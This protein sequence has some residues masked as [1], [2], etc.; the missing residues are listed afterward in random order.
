MTAREKRIEELKKRQKKFKENFGY[1]SRELQVLIEQE[2]KR[3]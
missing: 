1:E 3:K 2:E